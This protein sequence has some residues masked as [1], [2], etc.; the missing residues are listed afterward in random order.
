MS[1]QVGFLFLFGT[2]EIKFT[3]FLVS[4]YDSNKRTARGASSLKLKEA[5]PAERVPKAS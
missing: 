2:Y 4:L 3:Q 5:Q 1:E